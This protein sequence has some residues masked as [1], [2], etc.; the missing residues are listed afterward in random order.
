MALAAPPPPGGNAAELKVVVLADR[1]GDAALR[2]IQA[3]LDNVRDNFLSEVTKVPAGK[4]HVKRRDDGPMIAYRD[5][6]RGP[7]VILLDVE[8]RLWARFSY[9][10]AHE[11]C[12]LL[13]GYE[14]LTGDGDKPHPFG[15][16]HEALCE[17]ASLYTMRRMAKTWETAAPW[18]DYRHHLRSYVQNML[19]ASAR[20]LPPDVSLAE[21]YRV[22]SSV[23]RTKADLRELNAVAASRL[24]P[25]FE[26]DPSGW[27]TIARMPATRT[28]DLAAYLREWQR[29]VPEDAKAFVGR[30]ASCFGVVL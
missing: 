18:T 19:D 28:D 2:D 26:D 1:W 5:E 9:Q 8:G 29:Q 6:K 3:L 11:L 20:Q 22:N 23:L 24:L 17:V 14:E 16:L 15:W 13:M 27:R 30:V 7:Y 12:H 10:F 4:I 25:L 21:W